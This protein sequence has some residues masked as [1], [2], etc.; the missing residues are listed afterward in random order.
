MSY[1]SVPNT[2]E[3][4]VHGM[5]EELTR[6]HPHREAYVF[7]RGTE[8]WHRHHRTT[9]P[10]LVHQLLGAVPAGS[11]D[12]T[13]ATPHSRPAARIEGLDTLM[14]ID[15]EAT[16]WLARLGADDPNVRLDQRTRLPKWAPPRS[17]TANATIAVITRLHGLRA[18]QAEDV[19][20]R[21][22]HDVRRWWH[23]A[24]I[25]T[26][27]DS[28]SWRPDNTCPSCEQRRTLRV[29]LMMQAGF[30]IEC[31]VLWDAGSIGLLAEHIRAENAED[32]TGHAEDDRTA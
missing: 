15:D 13:G 6:A 2:T 27:W 23:Q 9:V 31:R 16:R 14:L 22:D 8:R 11:G 32:Q 7:E 18:G 17:S 1:L 19:R 25:I 24:R 20:Y 5:V 10:A 21:I 4:N 29:N 12:Q 30:C 28:P 3:P 26:G